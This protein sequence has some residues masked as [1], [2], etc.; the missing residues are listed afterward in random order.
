MANYN[1]TNQDI[2]AS[3][4]QLLQKNDDTGYLVNGTGSVVDGL[5][6]SGTISGSFVGDGS[7][8]TNIPHTDISSL[9]TFT[10]SQ[11]RRNM[12]FHAQSLDDYDKKLFF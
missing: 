1:L 3:F 2:S 4:Q 12:Y 7:G 5:T 6:I 11:D 10:A 8:L 9:N